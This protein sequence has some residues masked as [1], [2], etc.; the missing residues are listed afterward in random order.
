[1]PDVEQRHNDQ[2]AQHA[3]EPAGEA[4]VPAEEIARDHSADAQRP[5]VQHASM[6]PQRA[7]FQIPGVR[8]GIGELIHCT[9]CST[10]GDAFL[11]VLPGTDSG[12]RSS[13]SPAESMI[14]FNHA[15]WNAPGAGREK[16]DDAEFIGRRTSS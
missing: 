2:G 5:Q 13:F 10:G 14:G 6:T 7:L 1:E 15:W 3:A 8:R 12:T 16:F 11:A 9:L 4:E